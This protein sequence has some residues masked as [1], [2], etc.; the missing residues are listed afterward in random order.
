MNKRKKTSAALD[1]LQAAKKASREEEIRLHG[2]LISMRPTK[3]RQSKKVYNRKR[4]RKNPD[5]YDDGR[6][7]FCGYLNLF[8]LAI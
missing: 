6:D 8:R 1:A 3:I 2:K 5:R 4:Y 7:F